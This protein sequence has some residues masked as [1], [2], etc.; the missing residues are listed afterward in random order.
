M[1]ENIAASGTDVALRAALARAYAARSKLSRTEVEKRRLGALITEIRQSSAVGLSW[2]DPALG[3]S[4]EAR[5]KLEAVPM[6]PSLD[7]LPPGH[8]HALSGR[9]L[10]D[11][12]PVPGRS[13]CAAPK[14]RTTI[15][16]GEA[17]RGPGRRPPD[18]SP[19]RAQ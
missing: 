17:K 9:A 18:H 8:A 14:G 16:Q 13:V 15:A 7:L 10:P 3:I 19:L 1:A 11:T 5:R 4:P 6:P 2:D 12:P